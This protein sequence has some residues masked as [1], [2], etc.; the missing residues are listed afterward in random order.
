MNSGGEA[1]GRQEHGT[2]PF[3]V[4]VMVPGI[5]GMRITQ[6]ASLPL[7][8]SAQSLGA[9]ALRAGAHIRNLP[10]EVASGSL[11]RSIEIFGANGHSITALA[12][13]ASTMRDPPFHLPQHCDEPLALASYSQW[14]AP[15]APE[16]RIHRARGIEKNH[17]RSSGNPA[18]RGIPPPFLLFRK[19]DI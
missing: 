13:Q 16:A 3:H 15:S 17:S 1:D 14:T 10:L 7:L 19:L 2:Y 9:L 12:A 6:V 18:A 11:R 8:V 4:R 5:V